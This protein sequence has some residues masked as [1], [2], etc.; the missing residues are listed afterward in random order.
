[1]SVVVVGEIGSEPF[2]S[3]IVDPFGMLNVIVSSPAVALAE[4]NACRN[5]HVV[6]VGHVPVASLVLL[7][8]NVAADAAADETPR[9]IAAKAT[10]QASRAVPRE[11]RLKIP[12]ELMR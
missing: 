10:E 3:R 9:R 7:T 12:T 4:P 5:E 1:L 2:V 11:T 6:G 8:V